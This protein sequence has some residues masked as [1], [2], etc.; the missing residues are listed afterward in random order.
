MKDDCE[1]VQ[2]LPE[3]A[4]ITCY[5]GQFEK[6]EGLTVN[7]SEAVNSAG[8]VIA[9]DD[10]KPNVNTPE[11]KEGLTSWSTA[12]SRATSR[13]RPSPT[14]RRRAAARSRRAS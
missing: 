2:A 12:S 8:G 11:A 5:A 4:G 7:F 9:D 1:K 6:Y 13:R 10:G 14:R 3:G